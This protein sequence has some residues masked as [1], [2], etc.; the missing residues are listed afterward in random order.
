MRLKIAIAS[1]CTTLLTDERYTIIWPDFRCKVGFGSAASRRTA[2]WESPDGSKWQVVFPVRGMRGFY[3]ARSRLPENWFL[4]R[5]G[6]SVSE[7]Q[8]SLKL[9]Q[10]DDVKFSLEMT[11]ICW[12]SSIST[13]PPILHVR[14][15]FR[16]CRFIQRMFVADDELIAIA[17]IKARA[18]VM[19]ARQSKRWPDLP[20]LL[21]ATIIYSAS[22]SY[23]GTGS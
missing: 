20:N 19:V 3:A 15:D 2:F 10:P 9:L 4:V 6:R 12:S 1:L 18:Y 7:C 22:T 8:H 14:P 17:R 5:G 21:A 13:L 11:H 23:A 16:K